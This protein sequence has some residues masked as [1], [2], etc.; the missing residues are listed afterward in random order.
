MIIYHGRPCR[1]HPVVCK[2]LVDKYQNIGLYQFHEDFELVN[3]NEYT[4]KLGVLN[5]HPKQKIPE[6]VFFGSPHSC[7]TVDGILN[8]NMNGLS[9]YGL[10]VNAYKVKIIYG[11]FPSNRI[12]K[13]NNFVF[14]LLDHPIDYVYNCFY[15]F[16]FVSKSVSPNALKTLCA[17]YFNIFINEFIDNFIANGIPNFRYKDS[18][19]KI[20]EDIFYC[21]NLDIYDLIIFRESPE[22][23]FNKLNKLTN[24]KLSCPRIDSSII[25]NNTYRRA[26][27]EELLKND[28]IKYNEMK[29][30][31][32]K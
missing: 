19:Y 7:F 25:K 8:P 27:L 3:S 24:L 6:R 22:I 18:S 32:L 1:E 16:N 21:R 26:D 9:P 2:E 13:N 17:D 5:Y 4:R 11:V 12:D 20:I 23:G 14:T 30:K 28:V 29:E 15:Y 10:S 31:F